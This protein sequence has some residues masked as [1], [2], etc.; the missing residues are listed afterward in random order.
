MAYRNKLESKIAR[1]VTKAMSTFDLVEDGDRIMVGLSGGKDSW[2]LMQVLDVLRR[3]APV[4]FSLIAVN[5]DSGYASTSIKR[6]RVPAK[7][8]GGSIGSSTRRSARSWTTYSLRRDALLAVR[9][10]PARGSCIGSPLM[11]AR[12]RLRSDTTPMISLK[13][14]S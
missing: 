4:E 11:S 1:K 6:F 10:A 3:R 2:A 13:P 7:R 8:A 9:Q 5:V 12:P 14:C